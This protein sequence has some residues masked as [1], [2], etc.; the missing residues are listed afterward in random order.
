VVFAVSQER[1]TLLAQ[2]PMTGRAL[3]Q[4]DRGR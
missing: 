2:A 3:V 4:S 1:R